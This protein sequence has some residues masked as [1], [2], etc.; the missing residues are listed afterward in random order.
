MNSAVAYTSELDDALEA[1]AQLAA[2]IREK[3][4]LQKHSAG[5]LLCDADMDGA[6]V[7]AELSKLLG[8]EILGMTTLATL[9]ADGHHEAAAVLT[10]LTADDCIFSA[11]VSASLPGEDARAAIIE[12]YRAG[13]PAEAA[14]GQRPGLLMAFCPYGL[15]FSGDLY[16]AALSA[17]AGDAPVIGGVAS[18]DY[19]YERARVFLSGRSYKDA[20]VLLGLW[21]AVSP[22]FSIRHVTSRFA[23]RIRR[24]TEAEGNIVRRVGD[25]TFVQYLEGF[26]LN[27]DVSDP[28]LAFTCYPMMLIS[29]S[30]DEETPLM[31][32]I[33]GLNREDGSGAFFG[34][35]PVG[36][37]ANICLINKDDLVRACRESMGSLLEAAA[38]RP[39][40]TPSTILCI[41]CCGRAVILGANA[42]AEGKA[43]SE[44]LP[45]GISLAGA[46]CL[47]EICPTFYKDGKALNRFHNC[48]I[49]FCMF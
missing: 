43:L 33:C 23:E 13:V 28:L 17:A 2:Q 41:S 36:A 18:D 19:D 39:E 21:G 46:Y 44:M 29:D 16:P 6:A 34:D 12:A 9:D 45:P 47:G 25:E 7:S 22:V 3:L 42:G 10:V 14:P 20:M 48:S 38:A 26:G 27:T 11:S 40:Y 31:R 35:V 24:I 4:E 15:P 30:G 32:H 8:S 1:A 49:T 5:I 37:L